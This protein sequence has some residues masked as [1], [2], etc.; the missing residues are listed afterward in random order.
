LRT[1]SQ[2]QHT[3]HQDPEIVFRKQIKPGYWIETYIPREDEPDESDE[4]SLHEEPERWRKRKGEDDG[5]ERSTAGMVSR[6]KAKSGGR[7][8]SGLQD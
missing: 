2:T 1:R 6:K 8:M 7:R 5:D 4:T 3:Q